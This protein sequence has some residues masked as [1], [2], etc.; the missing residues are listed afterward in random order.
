M[1]GD[2]AGR[3]DQGWADRADSDRPRPLMARAVAVPVDAA[4]ITQ[5]DVRGDRIFYLVQPLG[6]IDGMLSGEKSELRFYDLNTRKSSL[7]T[8]DVDGYSLSRDGLR[9]LIRHERLTPCSRP[10]RCLQG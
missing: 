7:V 2:R 4:N 8:E 5:L 3:I 10:S 1:I 6:L 9:V